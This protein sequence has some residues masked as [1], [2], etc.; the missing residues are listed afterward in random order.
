MGFLHT[1]A[2]FDRPG[3]EQ[4]ALTHFHCQILPYRNAEQL[5]DFLKG[6][7][8]DVEFLSFGGGHGLGP[9]TMPRVLE[10]LRAIGKQAA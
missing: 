4:P 3:S 1:F 5:R 10:L 2:Y 7:G 9:Q 8:L 6:G